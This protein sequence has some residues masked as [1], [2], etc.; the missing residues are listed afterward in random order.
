[1]EFTDIV[2]KGVI[3]GRP[4]E[5]AVSLLTADHLKVQDLFKQFEELK[6]VEDGPAME[7]KQRIATEVCLELTMHMTLEEEIFYPA[8]RAMTDE[9]DLMNE[10][11]IEHQGVKALID[12]LGAMGAEDEM[13]N[14]RV[15]VLSDYVDH[16]IKQEH[17]ETFRKARDADLDLIALG[18]QL[19]SRKRE[20]ADSAQPAMMR[21][22]PAAKRKTS[23][24]GRGAA[25]Q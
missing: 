16:H 9:D 13:F 14:A 25:K 5:D 11:E 15:K 18:Q 12:E 22:A 8:V 19:M 7:E 17:A 10:S 21:V 6:D 3:S 24:R 2:P 1:M 4:G 23:A 20:L